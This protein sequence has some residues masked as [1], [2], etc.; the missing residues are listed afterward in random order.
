LLYPAELLALFDILIFRRYKH[1]TISDDII[2]KVYQKAT[3]FLSSP[4]ILGSFPD[5]PFFVSMMTIPIPASYS[6][7]SSAAFQSLSSLAC[8]RRG[9]R[10]LTS[11]AREQRKD[12]VEHQKKK[13]ITKLKEDSHTCFGRYCLHRRDHQLDR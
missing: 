2:L 4:Q 12:H 10:A 6:Q 13:K 11:G 3:S 8:S 9:T 7:A 1:S 5:G